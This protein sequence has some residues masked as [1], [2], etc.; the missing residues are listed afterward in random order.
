MS[1]GDGWPL[2]EAVPND[3]H[4]RMPLNN[5]RSLDLF[6]RREK[7]LGPLFT[8]ISQARISKLQRF[9]LTLEYTL[10]PDTITAMLD[11]L[12]PRILENIEDLTLYNLDYYDLP[13]RFFEAMPFA[14]LRRLCFG[15]GHDAGMV[16]MMDREIE[17]CG[18]LE[19]LAVSVTKA[20]SLSPLL[21]SGLPSLKAL[22]LLWWSGV[23]PPSSRADLMRLAPSLE[24]LAL[25]HALANQQSGS[26]GDSYTTHDD[27]P[28]PLYAVCSNL[29]FHGYFIS[30]DDMVFPAISEGFRHYLVSLSAFNSALYLYCAHQNTLGTVNSLRILHLRFPN[31]KLRPG[32]GEEIW[33]KNSHEVVERNVQ[34]FANPIITHLEDN[35]L[36]PVLKGLVF[37]SHWDADAR[38]RNH[39]DEWAYPRYCFIKGWQ[40]NLLGERS[41]TAVPVR[42]SEL[43]DLEL[44]C[45]LLDF[46]PQCQWIGG[47]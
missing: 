9:A 26:V 39:D 5:L 21:R 17:D 19:H 8:S 29:R 12:E 25:H 34:R 47:L 23:F 40:T 28:S 30:E 15:A 24:T 22:H 18:Q 35:A 11:N 32:E 43:R 2:H 16:D 14:N 42:E 10:V 3:L 37:G 27:S 13:E 45:D 36:C 44:S 7:H 6:M 33:L 38:R 4:S 41:A 1:W 31:I 20:N 46:D